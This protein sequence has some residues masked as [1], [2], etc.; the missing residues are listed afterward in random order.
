L[1][2]RYGEITFVVEPCSAPLPPPVPRLVCELCRSRAR[3]NLTLR[4]SFCP[5]HGV[6]A[7][8]LEIRLTE[9]AR[10]QRVPGW[11]S[12]R[13]HRLR[14]WGLSSS[15]SRALLSSLTPPSSGTWTTV[16]PVP[17]LPLFRARNSLPLPPPNATSGSQTGP[18]PSSDASN[19]SSLSGTW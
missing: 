12:C 3:H 1:T 13:D 4:I 17:Q 8:L 9:Y 7:E 6:A 18:G 15:P 19:G 16:V 2:P 11:V 14:Q 10:T 5:V